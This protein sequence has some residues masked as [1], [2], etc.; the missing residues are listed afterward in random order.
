ME[1]T[2]IDCVKEDQARKDT[3]QDKH[4]KI[5]KENW[6]R[7]EVD[8]L[9]HEA[10]CA[11]INQTNPLHPGVKQSVNTVTGPFALQASLWCKLKGTR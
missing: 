9:V 8:A 7:D 10:Y 4:P 2:L 3:R 5:L 11:G 6:S 1:K